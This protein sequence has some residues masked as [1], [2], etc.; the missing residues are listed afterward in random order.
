[1]PVVLRVQSPDG[2]KAAVTVE[3]DGLVADVILAAAQGSKEDVGRL[4]LVAGFPPKKVEPGDTLA[5]AQI[6]SNESVRLTTLAI[7]DPAVSGA[8]RCLALRAAQRFAAARQVEPKA[9]RKVEA[10][11][12]F[13]KYA[14]ADNSCLFN[15]V[16]FAVEGRLDLAVALR[17][18]VAQAIE[19]D[20]PR[21]E[22]TLEKAPAEY[23]QEMLKPETWGG[24]VELAILAE[25]FGLQIAVWD[26]QSQKMIINKE[27]AAQRIFLLFEGLHYDLL[28]AK[29]DAPQTVFRA[30]DEEAVAKARV[31]VAELHGKHQ[32]VDV[33]RFTL[34]CLV[35][36]EGLEGAA[37]AKDH[38]QATGHQAFAEYQKYQSINHL[39]SRAANR[40]QIADIWNWLDTLVV[41]IWYAER[42]TTTGF[43]LDPMILRLFR[44]SRLM[45][46]VRLVKIFEQCA[47]YLMLT[48]IRASFAAL[49]WSSALLLLIQM[50]LALAMVTLVEPYLSSAEST[51]QGRSGVCEMYGLN[52]TLGDKHAV[53]SYYGTFTRAMLTLFEITLGNFVPVTR[54]MMQD[55]SEI[56]V[57][58]ALIHKLV[59]GF[60]V[61]M[62]HWQV[63]TGVFVQETFSVAQ[64]DNTIMRLRR[65][66]RRSSFIRDSRAIQS[67]VT[68]VWAE[69]K[70]DATNDEMINQK[71]RALA[72]HVAKMCLECDSSEPKSVVFGRTALFKAA[73]FDGSGRLD[74]G[75]WLQVCDDY[76][77]QLWLSAMGLDVSNAALV[78]EL[79]CSAVG[80]QAGAQDLNAKDLVLGV[81]RLKGAARNID[82]ALFRQDIFSLGGCQRF[83]TS[84]D[85]YAA[86]RGD[87]AN[88]N[89][90]ERRESW[91]S[92]SHKEV[93]RYPQDAAGSEALSLASLLCRLGIALHAMHGF[94]C[95]QAV[96]ELSL[97]P[98]R[99]YETGYVL[100]L[101]GL[102]YFESADYKKSELAYNQAWRVEPFRVEGLEYYSSALWHLRRDVELCRLAQQCLQWDRLKPQ[103]WCVVGNCFS[104]QKE[105][106]A[107]VKLFKRAIQVDSTFTYAYTLCGHEFVASEK[108]DKAVAMYENAVR[109]DPRHYNAWRQG[110]Y[111]LMKL[112]VCGMIEG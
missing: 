40:G 101:V 110:V 75:E 6:R 25:F 18:L 104:L 28:V 93:R 81:A 46:M 57:I 82:M 98:K 68:F 44:L 90:R 60:A 11:L 102:S 91:R 32:F 31:V 96:Q 77:V 34:R 66:S 97:L 38:A 2:S 35:C 42:V 78:H 59:I 88:A 54:L 14:I 106:D 43:P 49:A 83:I 63:I 73:D 23:V 103:V 86:L 10:S 3:D 61:V 13:E 94:N 4:A 51:G 9:P 26:L 67:V 92:E 55:V 89:R 87:K 41:C 105:H 84:G 70:Y 95:G 112:H 21:C 16:G 69:V 39:K 15:A 24:G 37:A 22:A 56:Y 33:K 36:Q 65:E 79:I 48:S 107:A 72:L 7:D 99:H 47:L 53:Y 29:E 45:R 52:I 20:T 80:K 71:E 111:F 12:A 100:D 62:E 30:E 5:G 27:D 17:G 76:S 108:I 109:L 8:R 50:M 74:L 85:C 1:M 19:A 58:F 64:T